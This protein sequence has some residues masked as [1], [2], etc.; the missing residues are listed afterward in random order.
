MEPVQTET[1]V[2]EARR[3]VQALIERGMTANEIAEK[4]DHRVSSRTVYRWAKGKSSPQQMSDLELLRAIS[5][6]K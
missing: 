4:L 1:P 6:E 5:A 2:E 3:L